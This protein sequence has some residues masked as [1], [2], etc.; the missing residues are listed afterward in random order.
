MRY[1]LTSFVSIALAGSSAQGSHRPLALYRRDP[2]P[3]DRINCRPQLRHAL[4]TAQDVHMHELTT[5]RRQLEALSTR[6]HA[7]VQELVARREDAQRQL[8]DR[9]YERNCECESAQSSL[10]TAT[11][12]AVPVHAIESDA[13]GTLVPDNASW[14]LESVESRMR[15]DSPLAHAAADQQQTGSFFASTLFALAVFFMAVPIACLLGFVLLYRRRRRQR[16][17]HTH[18]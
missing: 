11:S 8:Y 16:T 7:E 12:T 9:Q 5:A 18:A 13:S 1:T 10:T 4:V 3:H 14:A 17:V 15:S 6:V 2:S